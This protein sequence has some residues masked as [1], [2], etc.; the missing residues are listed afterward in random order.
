MAKEKETMKEMFDRLMADPNVTESEMFK[1]SERFGKVLDELTAA[2]VQ[3]CLDY[4]EQHNED[5]EGWSHT[6]LIAIARATCKLTYAFQK[7]SEEK[8]DDKDVFD[9]YLEL[10]PLCKEIA[11]RESEDQLK[12]K[13]AIEKSEKDGVPFE[14][15][16][17]LIQAIADPAKTPEEILAQFFG[18]DISDKKRQQVLDTIAQMRSE[19]ADKLKHVHDHTDE[20]GN[21]K[22]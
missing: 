16:K 2:I 5:D 20:N 17:R 6:I 13:E 14:T 22:P 18:K 10:L 1:N 19:H 15:K 12:M 3:P 11:Y 8:G 7:T 21:W 9:Y 4:A